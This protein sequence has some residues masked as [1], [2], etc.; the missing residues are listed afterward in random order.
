MWLMLAHTL[1]VV[2]HPLIG[3]Q[4]LLVVVMSPLVGRVHV[5]PRT[6]T[7]VRLHVRRSYLHT[8]RRTHMPTHKQFQLA[9]GVHMPRYI[10]ACALTCTSDASIH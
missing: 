5:I 4:P 8:C 7:F 2:S 1:P 10:N 9:T 6:M 3:S